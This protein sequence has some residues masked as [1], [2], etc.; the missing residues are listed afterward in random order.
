MKLLPYIFALCRNIRKGENVGWVSKLYVLRTEH[1]F[2]IK[3]FSG[4]CFLKNIFALS[5][6]KL[7]KT[8]IIR[9]IY[10]ALK[11]TALVQ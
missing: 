1:F 8:K 10:D 9:C 3:Y 4:I 7:T 5:A 2:F 6:L 11:L